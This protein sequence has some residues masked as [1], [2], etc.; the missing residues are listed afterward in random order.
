MGGHPLHE[1]YERAVS[2]TDPYGEKSYS[3]EETSFKGDNNA[4][5]STWWA[6]CVDDTLQTSPWFGLGWGYDLAEPF[7]RVYYPEGGDVFSAR[8]PHN[9]FITVF[10]RTGLVGLLPFLCMV[11]VIKSYGTQ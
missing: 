5:R 2:L 9:V 3:G 10:A 1:M 11:F 8:S 6:I 4:F 7:T